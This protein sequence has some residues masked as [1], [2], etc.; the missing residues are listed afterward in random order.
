MNIK[1][2]I[3][4]LNFEDWLFI[5]FIIL[6]ILNIY[7]DN[8]LKKY[9]IENKEIYENNANEIFLIT[10]IITTIIYIYFFYRNYKI[11]KNTSTARKKLL[12]IKVLSSIFFIIGG[13]LLIYFQ[14]KDNNFIGAPSI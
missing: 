14:I 9:L 2:E 8:L 7:G 10:T 4:R 13:V 12:E 3:N 6:S 11:Y 1:D 5:I